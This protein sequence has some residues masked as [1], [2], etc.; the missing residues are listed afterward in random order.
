MTTFI[1]F[2]KYVIVETKDLNTVDLFLS[3][4]YKIK[5]NELSELI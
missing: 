3:K 2:N 5:Y 1:L 4:G